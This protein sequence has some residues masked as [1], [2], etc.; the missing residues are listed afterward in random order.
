MATEREKMLRGELYRAFTPDLIAARTRC[1]W[2]CN[3][4]N[5]SEEVS[6]RR[7][8]EMWKDITEDKTP[9][10]PKL[11]DPVA[12]DDLFRDEPWIEAP[13][14]IDYGFN[15]Q[16]GEGVFINFNC[17]FIDTCPIIIGART[18]FGPNVSLFSGTHPLDPALRNGTEDPELGRPIR[19]GEDCWLGGNVI[20]LAGVTIGKGATIG[21]GSVVTKDVPAFHVAAGNPARIIRRIETTMTV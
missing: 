6:R 20:V 12:D 18:M 1:K 21:A 11:D 15:L 16:L 17:V 14:K 8:V 10:P 2:A 13:V 9:L 19:I 7:L 5:N 4:Y 3:R